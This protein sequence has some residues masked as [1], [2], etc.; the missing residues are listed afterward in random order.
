M[1]KKKLNLTCVAGLLLAFIPVVNLVG[2]ILC[3]R[4]LNQVNARNEDGKVFAITGLVVGTIE[5]VV[6]IIMGI[7]AYNYFVNKVSQTRRSEIVEVAN[8]SVNKAYE[9]YAYD[10][11]SGIIQNDTGYHI[12]NINNIGVKTNRTLND[13]F[14]YVVVDATS[15]DYYEYIL[16]I[17]SSEL[18]L[19]NYRYF[20]YGNIYADNN[21]IVKYNDKDMPHSA[22]E[23]CT[24]LNGT[25]CYGEDGLPLQ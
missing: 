5:I 3:A 19:V 21:R 8:Q 9:Q 11:Q 18:E 20:D 6:M 23:V 22:K 1:E 12:Y 7:S 14:G 13:Y 15:D 16:F 2:I 25:E 24:I 10:N 4:G 17:S